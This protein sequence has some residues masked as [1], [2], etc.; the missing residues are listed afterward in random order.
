MAGRGCLPEGV[1]VVCISSLLYRLRQGVHGAGAQSS[2]CGIPRLLLAERLCRYVSS[3]RRCL[4]GHVVVRVLGEN[5]HPR[6]F[7]QWKT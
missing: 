5:T 6:A 2:S 7:S 1:E 3:V 4:W